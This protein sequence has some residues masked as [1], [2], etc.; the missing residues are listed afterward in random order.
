MRGNGLIVSNERS[1]YDL[2]VAGYIHF[3]LRVD[4]IFTPGNNLW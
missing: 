2:A 3:W 1:N 4:E